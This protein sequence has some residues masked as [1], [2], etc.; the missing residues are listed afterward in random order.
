MY[1]KREKLEIDFQLLEP[2]LRDYLAHVRV[3]ITADLEDKD[4]RLDPIKWNFCEDN[5]LNRSLFVEAFNRAS[6][7]IG[8]YAVRAES[9]YPLSWVE[10]DVPQNTLTSPGCS[11]RLS[12]ASS[13]DI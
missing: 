11:K 4:H 2:R 9:A 3:G 13:A 10:I 5:S 1:Y 12:N 7:R 6:A 8:A